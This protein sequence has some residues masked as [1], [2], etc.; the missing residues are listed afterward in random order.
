MEKEFSI[1][2]WVQLDADVLKESDKVLT[3]ICATCHWVQRRN[4]FTEQI[5]RDMKYDRESVCVWERERERERER[6]TGR[7][8]CLMSKESV[9]P[10]KEYLKQKNNLG[11]KPVGYQLTRKADA[12]GKTK[13]V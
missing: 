10:P 8:K 1:D 3:L 4:V 5:A 9:A 6:E 13:L 12:T 7:E 2:R 11:I